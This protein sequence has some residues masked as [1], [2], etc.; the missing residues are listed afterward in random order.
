[1][2]TTDVFVIHLE[3]AARTVILAI[4]V[5]KICNKNLPSYIEVQPWFIASLLRDL[6]FILFVMF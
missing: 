6:S 3:I 1:M 5:S 2:P 4:K